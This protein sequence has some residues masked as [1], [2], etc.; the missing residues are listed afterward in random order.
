MN[1][2]KGTRRLGLDVSTIPPK[3][4][5]AKEKKN[6]KPEDPGV[7]PQGLADLPGLYR[8]KAFGA[9]F[10]QLGSE[11]VQLHEK[12]AG[13]FRDVFQDGGVGYG[14]LHLPIDVFDFGRAGV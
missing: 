10:Q 2:R 1:S 13:F 11:L 8:F 7:Q 9:A 3:S 14:G 5:L 12:P 4:P 6:E